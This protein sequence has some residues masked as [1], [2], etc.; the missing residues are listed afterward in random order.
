MSEKNQTTTAS[1]LQVVQKLNEKLKDD[2]KLLSGFDCSYQFRIGSHTWNLDLT[3]GENP[4][5]EAGELPGAQCS[6]EVSEDNFSKLVS[7][8]LNIAMA[9]LFGKVKIK[10]DKLLA[11][12]LS[13]LFS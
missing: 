7:G 1:V 5:V 3:Q 6:I 12:K 11:T 9:L 2:P 8:K 10:G 4:Q 13:K